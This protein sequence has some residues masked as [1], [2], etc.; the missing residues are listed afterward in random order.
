MFVA[1]YATK[2]KL[3]YDNQTAKLKWDA[4]ADGTFVLVVAN[5]IQEWCHSGGKRSSSAELCKALKPQ[6]QT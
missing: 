3:S 5:H 6:A 4:T 1:A 2:P